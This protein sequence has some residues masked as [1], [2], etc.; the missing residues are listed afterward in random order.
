MTCSNFRDFGNLF[1]QLFTIFVIVCLCT[2]NFFI[3]LLF[4]WVLIFVHLCFLVVYL[5]SIQCTLVFVTWPKLRDLGNLFQDPPIVC[6]LCI[7]LEDVLGNSR[8]TFEILDITK[9]CAAVCV[10]WEREF[11]FAKMESCRKLF[12]LTPKLIL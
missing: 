6:N 5:Y 8:G 10:G 12:H 7:E 9:K 2:F 3:Y 1:P 11:A 4:I